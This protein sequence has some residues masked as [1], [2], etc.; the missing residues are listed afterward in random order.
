MDTCDLNPLLAT[1]PPLFTHQQLDQIDR[2][3]IYITVWT[4]NAPETN[5]I[6]FSPVQ[7]LMASSQVW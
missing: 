7:L 1:T 2:V 3:F 4:I 6:P 5:S